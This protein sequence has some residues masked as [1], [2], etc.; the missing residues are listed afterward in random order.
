MLSASSRCRFLCYKTASAY[1]VTPMTFVDKYEILETVGR[2]RV[3]TFVARKV[4]TDQ[5]V[6][7]HV[8][9]G[10]EQR[11]EE[12]TVQWVLESFRAL[13]PSPPEVVVETGR[14]NGTTYAYLVT[15][16]PDRS[17][18]QDWLR[19]YEAQPEATGRPEVPPERTMIGTAIHEGGPASPGESLASD[20]PTPWP[21]VDQPE[22]ITKVFEALRAKLRPEIEAKPVPTAEDAN[23][24]ASG[25]FLVSPGGMDFEPAANVKRDPGEF[26]MEFLS[27]FDHERRAGDHSAPASDAPTLVLGLSTGQLFTYSAD[28]KG[29]GRR[30]DSITEVAGSKSP[31]ANDQLDTTDPANLLGS[32]GKQPETKLP[33]TA[34][35]EIA[36]AKS[37]ASGAGE[38]TNFFQGPFDG[39]KP[40][41]TP[42]LSLPVSKPEQTGDFTRLFGRMKEGSSPDASAA[43][44]PN[45]DSQAG[46]RRGNVYE[47]V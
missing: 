17:A 31:K 35:R 23:A 1:V 6:L 12:P 8:F 38:F 11:P 15:K 39:E 16:L 46:R 32:S 30:Q 42:E 7:V 40:S 34:L 21:A 44:P 4:S 47:V 29:L 26:T 27:G 41:N 33:N 37:N 5:R 43:Q 24:G 22:E 9:E 20:Q 45:R 14:Y 25:A 3:E 28:G 2:G 13:A 18:L 10:R 36:S 19:S